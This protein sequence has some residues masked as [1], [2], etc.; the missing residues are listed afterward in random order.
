MKSGL[1]GLTKYASTYWPKKVRANCICP[2]GILNNQSEDL[3]KEEILKKNKL[4]KKFFIS[5]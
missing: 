5:L 1:I 3:L 2:G 4:I